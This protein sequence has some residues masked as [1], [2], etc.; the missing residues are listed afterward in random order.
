MPNY[1]QFYKQ[2]Q[3]WWFH[4][5][6]QIFCENWYPLKLCMGHKVANAP[7]RSEIIGL[8]MLMIQR[9][10][11][12]S[13]SRPTKRAEPSAGSISPKCPPWVLV[14]SPSLTSTSSQGLDHNTKNFFRVSNM[15]TLIQE[16]NLLRSCFPQI[17]E[18]I[19]FTTK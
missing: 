16:N 10:P 9:M 1:S 6:Q 18:T 7:Q 17:S 2:L 8:K 12:G 3:K 4:K 14:T 11:W 19:N 15:K 5:L 13:S